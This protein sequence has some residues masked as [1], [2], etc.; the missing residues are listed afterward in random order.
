ML[1][2]WVARGVSL[3]GIVQVGTLKRRKD[4]EI[5]GPVGKGH[6]R[7]PRRKSPSSF[8]NTWRPVDS[9]FFSPTFVFLISG[10]FQ[11]SFHFFCLWMHKYLHLSVQWADSTSQWSQFR[12]EL[13]NFVKTMVLSWSRRNKILPGISTL[14]FLEPTQGATS[15]KFHRCLFKTLSV[16][17]FCLYFLNKT[18]EFNLRYCSPFLFIY[19]FIRSIN[20][21]IQ[22]SSFGTK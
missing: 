21:Q 19:S 10:R 2:W 4:L 1:R 15:S 18:Y 12:V 8:G 9:L 3:K 14:K 11:F 16:V 5:E 22:I 6:P 17:A 7:L 20:F 13:A